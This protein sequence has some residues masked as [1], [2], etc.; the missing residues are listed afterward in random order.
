MDVIKHNREAWNR[1]S[2]EGSEWCKPVTPEVIQAARQGSWSVVL[3]PNKPVPPDWLGNIRAKR[4]LCL[5]SGGG[6]QAPVL[7]A[8]GAC[9]TSF[10][11]SEEQLSK[12]R[13]VASREGL[14]L[15]CEQG[16]MADLSR[17]PSES[18]DLIFHP[19]SNVFVP[20][21]MAVWRECYRVLRPAGV[22]LAA[23]MN[24][25]LFLFNHSEVEKA[26]SLIV[27]YPLPYGEPE[28]LSASEQARWRESGRP[29]EFS[30]SLEAQIG[31]Q[32][33]AGFVLT[34]LYEDNWS[35][36]ATLFNKF[37]PVAIAT[38]AVK[39]PFTCDALG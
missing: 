37:A 5:A 38:R 15:S 7:A 20:E 24:P 28:S 11:L 9:V 34:G 8:A 32:C 10:D 25:S 23:F 12:D 3:T 6:Q 27:R 29:A 16:N 33:S 22:L 2:R 36:K 19:V 30:H 39:P 35:D 18:F 26:G 17:F 21:V 4:V 13:E 14:N 1:E 31:G